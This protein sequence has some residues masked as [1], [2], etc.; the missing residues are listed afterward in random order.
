M[1]ENTHLV[2]HQ[3]ELPPLESV[4]EYYGKYGIKG[5][6]ML[7]L[8]TQWSPDFFLIHK[9]VYERYITLPEPVRASLSKPQ[10][11]PDHLLLFEYEDPSVCSPPSEH[12]FTSEE[13]NELEVALKHLSPSEDAFLIV[14]SSAADENLSCKGRYKSVECR[15]S[16]ES[17]ISAICEVFDSC[18]SE[19]ISSMGILVQR[20]VETRRA[21]GHLSN[22]KRVSKKISHWVCEFDAVSGVGSPRIIR[23]GSMP[24]QKHP[25]NAALLC[26]SKES[27]L[28]ILKQVAAWAHNR[29]LRLHFEWIWDGYHLW[30]VQSDSVPVVK[31]D[32][33]SASRVY[34]GARNVPS[35]LTVLACEQELPLGICKKLDCV[36]MFRAQ[37]LP[38]TDLWVLHDTEVLMELHNGEL[39]SELRDDINV[40]LHAPIVIRTDI[41]GETTGDEFLLPRTDTVKNIHEVEEF[42]IAKASEFTRAI[43]VQRKPC[44]IFHRFIP[45]YSSAFALAEPNSNRVKIDGLWGL[46][47]GLLYYPHDSY[48]VSYH[49]TDIRTHLRFKDEFLDMDD[50]G[51]WLP[52]CAGT[53]YDWK[54]SLTT[55]DLQQIAK[56]TYAIAREV[57]GPVQLMWFTGIPPGLGH[58]TSLP[59]YF[60]TEE[61]PKKLLAHRIRLAS[62]GPVIRNI[63]DVERLKAEVQEHRTISTIRLRPAPSLLRCKQFIKDVSALAKLLSTPVVLEGS[64]LSHAY[65][66][67]KRCGVTV[68]CS[69]PFAPQFKSK[70]FNKLV[71]DKIQVRIESHGEKAKVM[72]LTGHELSLV[73]RAKVLEEALELFWADTPDHRKEEIADL[74]EVLHSLSKHEGFKHEELEDIA[75]NKRTERGGFDEGLVLKETLDVPLIHV[76]S[77]PTALFDNF[78]SLWDHPGA[79]SPSQVERAVIGHSPRREG[80]DTIIPLIPPNPDR[81]HFSCPPIPY[82]SLGVSL[83]IRFR[84]K[85]IVVEVSK[86]EISV[87]HEDMNQ[88][89]LFDF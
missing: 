4:S 83:N 85:D 32:S 34:I 51:H 68:I 19:S 12:L 41:T 64:V 37:G 2:L 24:A 15:A 25:H 74:L 30:I 84:E 88:L 44:F 38:T 6:G 75:T 56:G 70:R 59:W 39:S 89:K 54:S 29:R 3:G 26:E 42:L 16:I 47:D 50:K 61:L 43:I 63:E 7:L 35:R 20:Y 48:D 66:L 72:R 62:K 60:S 9:S 58:P 27:V 52:K 76:E 13:Y 79:I 46:P 80:P 18:P 73:L 55:K 1:G 57:G 69:D 22:E 36:K 65:Y 49:G 45:A 10:E 78:D 31:G 17:A 33:P 28:Q 81:R 82:K 40:L 77:G 5:A 71:R 53:P 21:S 8:P 11:R 14:R 67:L 87:K 23:F 86:L